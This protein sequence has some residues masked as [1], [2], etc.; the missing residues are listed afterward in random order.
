MNIPYQP[1]E[2]TT[3][4]LL[5]T[6][7]LAV[8]YAL[9]G[10]LGLA[11][12][13]GPK[14]VTAIWPPSG[15]ALAAF[16]L[17]RW[18]SIPGVLIGS[19][20]LNVNY[21][22]GMGMVGSTAWQGAFFMAAG[23]ALQACIA[24][25]AT[26]K[27]IH[28]VVVSH[29]LK[30]SFLFVVTIIVC[31]LIAPS[32][33]TFGLIKAGVLNPADLSY[34]WYVWWGGDC[35]G[36]LV[37]SPFIL[38]LVSPDFRKSNS[39][40]LSFLIMSVGFGL[41]TMAVLV[42]GSLEREK[43]VQSF[44]SR[45]QLLAATL[46]NHIDLVSKDL[47]SFQL[48]F[49][50]ADIQNEDFV[51][52]AQQL[53]N[54]SPFVTG[55]YYLPRVSE[56]QQPNF[57]DTVLGGKGITERNLDEAILPVT[58]RLEYF[59]LQVSYPPVAN[60]FKGVDESVDWYRNKAFEYARR[61]GKIGLTNLVPSHH[62]F[63]DR[64][65]ATQQVMIAY[66]PIFFNSIN[67]DNTPYSNNILGMVAAE[68]RPDKLLDE[69]L[70]LT[71]IDAEVVFGDVEA[72]RTSIIARQLLADPAADVFVKKNGVYAK[73]TFSFANQ[74]W[75]LVT[76][77]RDTVVSHFSLLQAGILAFGVTFSLLLASYIFLKRARERDLL[78]INESLE[79]LVEERTASLANANV[80]LKNEI[81]SVKLLTA[82]LE[83]AREHADSANHAKSI[84]L[85]NMSHEIRTPLN[86]VIGY[87]QLLLEDKSVN[88]TVKNKLETILI[89]G[90]RLLRLINDILDISK[91]E[92]GKIQLKY[93]SF[94]LKEELLET[95]AL[96][97]DKAAKKDLQLASVIHLPSDLTV[98]TDKTKLSQIVSNLLSNAV[99]Y[100]DEGGIH[101]S[102]YMDES[103]LVILVKD[104][105][106]G[107]SPE[108]QAHLFMP[109][110]Q[111][112]EGLNKG[113]TGLGLSLS[114]EFAHALGGELVLENLPVGG[115]IAKL[116]L[117]LVNL[118][119]QQV[120]QSAGIQSP[121]LLQQNMQLKPQTSCHAL[122]VDDDVQSLDILNALLTA[123]GCNTYVAK[124]GL[125]ALDQLAN[126]PIDI[127]FS[128]IRMPE[129][130][131]VTMIQQ[132]R[133]D[134]KW[135]DIPAIA[136]TA[137]SLLA[138]HEFFIRQ[139]YNEFVGKPYEF[140]T[141]LALLLKYQSDKF[142]LVD[143]AATNPLQNDP[144]TNVQ[145][146]QLQLL[147]QAAVSEEYSSISKQMKDIRIK[148]EGHSF[149]AE[150]EKAY[151]A[152]DFA[153]IKTLVNDVITQ[154]TKMDN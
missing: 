9:L 125:E 33:G 149:L 43:W 2:K 129:M 105:G 57:E 81:D 25:L 32:I 134:A 54:K 42:V 84:F 65:A 23:S 121:L 94:H 152:L 124:H 71:P 92:S 132:I 13:L 118:Q 147:L 90:Q 20:W 27:L 135:S 45:S 12:A 102:A 145:L 82:E 35:A 86:S 111:G 55:F 142:E 113:G 109:F 115:L 87:T 116:T 79:N 47:Q 69:A 103:A 21:M 68:I 49:Y 140:K 123:C 148:F 64:S 73:Q 88:P 3:H 36:I 11:L 56:D 59:P 153:L 120:S 29:L 37:F 40:W 16:I 143:H 85:A 70:E 78:V 151:N 110:V 8:L 154:S 114:R 53:K 128:D 6:A 17:F 107:L 112:L 44:Q 52:V 41:T 7:I 146:A 91:I 89:A 131:G 1:L 83:V 4:K 122:V 63:I 108:M 18:Q 100:T 66:I 97:Q 39:E 50:K 26:S 38:W 24:G 150:I 14:L 19:M 62:L 98:I 15:L 136:V 30:R 60:R 51:R 130:D 46:Q 31:S 141:I 80:Q 75:S 58:P 76:T 74:R 126:H 22:H 127:I 144:L 61:T 34:F 28:Q 67:G 77:P 101:C 48:L 10:A 72:P 119:V 133:K 99:K 96:F 106:P 95:I 139:G 117:P 138:E 104:T 5:L 93:S 137:S